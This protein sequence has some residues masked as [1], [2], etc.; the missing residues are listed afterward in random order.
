M[1]ETR[2]L[3]GCS[4]WPGQRFAER[5]VPPEFAMRPGI[6]LHLAVLSILDTVSVLAYLMSIGVAPQFTT[7]FRKLIHSQKEQYPTYVTVDENVIRVDDQP[8]RL[9]VAVDPDTERLLYVRLFPTRTQATTEMS[10]TALR[11]KHF[12]EDAIALIHWLT[13]AVDSLTSP[14]TPI[15]IRHHRESQRCRTGIQKN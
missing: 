6:Q 9:C 12:L 7:G 14:L 2:C 3:T 4:E 11:E 8:Y 5:E 1:P 15:L 13:V 10:L